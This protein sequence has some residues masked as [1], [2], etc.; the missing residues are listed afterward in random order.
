M[1]RNVDRVARVRALRS[2]ATACGVQV[3]DPSAGKT[4][5]GAMVAAI[6]GSSAAAVIKAK[7]EVDYQR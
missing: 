4:K 3:A 7:A 6:R 1:V 5:V 2:H